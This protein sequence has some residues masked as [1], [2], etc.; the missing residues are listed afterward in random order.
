MALSTGATDLGGSLGYDLNFFL[1]ELQLKCS[2]VN[3]AETVYPNYQWV[4]CT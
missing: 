2:N 4:Y 3:T 1:Q